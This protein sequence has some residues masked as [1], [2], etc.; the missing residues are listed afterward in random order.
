MKK[1]LILAFLSLSIVSIVAM[2]GSAPAFVDHRDCV[3]CH[4]QLSSI[5]GEDI[6][7]GSDW[8]GS[9]MANSSRD[10]YWQAAIRRETMRLP[11]A[12]QAIQ[13]ECAACHMPMT[14]Y[15]AK[16]AGRLG[17]VFIHFPMMP[18]EAL[19]HHLAADGV[20]CTMCHQIL[21]DKLGTAESFVGGF[22]LDNATPYGERGIYGPYDV[23]EGRQ[24]LMQSASLFIPRQATHIQSSEFCAT[25]HTLYTHAL[26]DQGEEIGILP[27]QVPY[28]EWKHSG[29]ADTRSCQSCHMPEVE[30]EVAISGVLGEPREKVSRHVFRGGNILAPRM[31]NRYRDELGVSAM[32]Q[33]LQATADRSLAHLEEKAARI[34]VLSAE[35]G[36]D[37]V[38]VEVEVRNLA[39]HKLP[40]AYPSR[41][42]WIHFTVLDNEGKVVF[43]SGKLRPDGAIAGNDNDERAD[44]FEPHYREIT[45]CD[46]VQIYEPIMGDHKGNVTTML[47]S[48]VK[49]L[50]DNRILPMGFDKATSPEDCGVYGAAAEDRDFRAF[51]DRITYRIPLTPGLEKL[52][53]QVELCYQPIGYRWAHNLKDTDAAETKRF[54]KYF[55]TFAPSSAAVLARGEAD[56][57]R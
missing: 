49:Y 41:R 28:L 21:A 1:L 5:Q 33:S 4:N 14:R 56:W 6:S 42:A 26:N 8:S 2:T 19:N 47:L 3:A 29:Y 15:L 27:E 35:A 11:A 57:S 10:P 16:T 34:R 43:E 50:K 30:G 55:K 51:T 36:D 37:C 45:T 13:H 48:G 22:V 23:D 32:P 18:N 24:H 20:S 40:T 46:Q 54:V 25:C 53:I 52:R 44:R 7:M 38:A 17:E 39:G 12:S 31:L 9:M